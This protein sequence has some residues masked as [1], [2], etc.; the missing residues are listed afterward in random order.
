MEPHDHLQYLG[1][2]VELGLAGYLSNRVLTG[3]GAGI[4]RLTGNTTL[5]G[6]VSTIP[7]AVATSAV[8]AYPAVTAFEYLIR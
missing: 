8:L 7:R 1:F 6:L 5:E 4:R 2:M 3:L